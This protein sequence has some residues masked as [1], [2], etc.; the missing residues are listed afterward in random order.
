MYISTDLQFYLMFS[1]V[2]HQ[3]ELVA[4]EHLAVEG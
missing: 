3:R 4:G 2:V 1:A